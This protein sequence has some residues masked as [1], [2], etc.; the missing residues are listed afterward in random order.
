MASP[1]NGNECWA[2]S[3]ALR[4]NRWSNYRKSTPGKSHPSS[5]Q[6]WWIPARQLSYCYYWCTW[7]FNIYGLPRVSK[8]NRT[9]NGFSFS[10]I[11]H[12]S[13]SWSFS[14]SEYCPYRPTSIW[15]ASLSDGTNVGLMSTTI[16][17]VSLRPS[18]KE[19]HSILF[20]SP[21]MASRICD[22]SFW[23]EQAF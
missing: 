18:T 20:A 12:T 22:L 8:W 15:D 16:R 9:I 19:I 14:G 7:G 2:S 6:S 5:T 4:Y 3:R 11:N 23:W 10:V 1:V 17:T 13:A 21:F